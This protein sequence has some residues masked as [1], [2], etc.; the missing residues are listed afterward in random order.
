LGD[1]KYHR[2]IRFT[3]N[4]IRSFNGHFVHAR[5]VQGLVLTGNTIELS[6]SYPTGSTRPSI[7]LDYC[8]DVRIEDNRFLDFTWPIRIMSTGGTENVTA[9]NNEGLAEQP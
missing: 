9:K 8:E 1:Q 4:R 7:E 2:N 6:T 3:G 5:S